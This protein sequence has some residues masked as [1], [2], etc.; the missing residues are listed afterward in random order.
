MQLKTRSETFIEEIC[1]IPGGEG[2]KRCIQCGTCTASCPNADKM[3]HTPA[4]LIAMARAGMRREVLSSNAMWYCLS[5]YL[6]T[7]RC[8]RGIKQTGL[9]HAFESLAMR[10]GVS[11]AGS[12]TPTMYRSFNH[13]ACALG[14][15]P[16]FGFMT[17]FYM[18]S[19]PLRAWKMIPI[20]LELFRHGRLSIK[21]RRLTPEG[22]KQL[23]AILEKAET[24]GGVT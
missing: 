16:E 6:C 11:Y 24:L 8:P 21:A 22:T 5:C 3:D 9:M 20:A 2:I 15:M 17:W 4:E 18:L 23:R 19:N 12:F 1:D 7:V 14:S 10:D 13:F